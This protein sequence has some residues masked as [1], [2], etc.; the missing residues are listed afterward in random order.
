MKFLILKN[1]IFSEETAKNLTVKL[2][3][4]FEGD[5]KYVVI[6]A[7]IEKTVEVYEI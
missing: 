2:M 1:D 3:Q 7:A 5:E 4:I 6:T